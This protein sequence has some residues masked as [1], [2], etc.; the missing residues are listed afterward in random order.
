MHYFSCQ[1]VSRAADFFIQHDVRAAYSWR[2][3]EI[4]DRFGTFSA[5][6]ASKLLFRAE[7]IK[8]T[9]K[10]VPVFLKDISFSH[11]KRVRI[12]FFLQIHF[13]Y[14]FPISACSCAVCHSPHRVPDQAQFSDFFF[15]T[16]VCGYTALLA[17]SLFHALRSGVSLV[18][19]QD[20]ALTAGSDPSLQPLFHYEKLPDSRVSANLRPIWNQICSDFD[21]RSKR[22]ALSCEF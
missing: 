15:L 18:T 19:K 2:R 11:R 1:L 14:F 21:R 9:D 6:L 7:W 13:C 10:V 16:L 4:L 20:A 8:P 17:T 5:S 12:F 22:Q 3:N